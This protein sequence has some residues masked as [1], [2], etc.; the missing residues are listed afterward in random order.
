MPRSHGVPVA[1]GAKKSV[2]LRVCMERHVLRMPH[3]FA[4]Q[5]YATIRLEAV[6][7]DGTTLEEVAQEMSP[8]GW[9]RATD[10]A[11]LLAL[12]YLVK[13]EAF[14]AYLKD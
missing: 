1:P 2:T 12:K 7:G 14:I 4:P 11:S 8:G 13:N 10:A 5:Y 3:V 9:G 6:L